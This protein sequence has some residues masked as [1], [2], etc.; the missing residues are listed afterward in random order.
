MQLC[1]GRA[2]GTSVPAHY[3]TS[4]CNGAYEPGKSHK[5]LA[6]TQLLLRRGGAGAAGAA[7]PAAEP[8]PEPERSRPPAA[9]PPRPR[10][11][12]RWRGNG[13][14]APA[15]PPAPAP[16]SPC[17][18]PRREHGAPPCLPR[19]AAGQ[20]FPLPPLEQPGFLRLCF[21]G[22]RWER[23]GSCSCWG[24]GASP[25]SRGVSARQITDADVKKG[26]SR[27]EASVDAGICTDGLR[28]WRRPAWC[29]REVE[30]T[31]LQS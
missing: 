26:Q 2:R 28:R 11:P 1:R 10:Y 31:D 22:R 3:V 15:P 17:P 21:L 9:P 25:C 19:G 27:G 20:V 24:C 4:E 6:N 13:L 7:G 18:A 30:N 12:R 29:W 5:P 8:E 16:R 23:V 14:A